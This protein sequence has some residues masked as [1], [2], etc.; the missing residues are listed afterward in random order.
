[1][2]ESQ[3]QGTQSSQSSSPSR[4]SDPTST[5]K[6]SGRKKQ[7]PR[8][9]CWNHFS[10]YVT[11]DG[12]NRS[13]CNHCDTTYTME[14]RGS[15]TSLNNHL[16]TCLQKPKGNTSDLKQ[17]ELAFSKVGSSSESETTIFSTWK[18]DGDAI[19][20]ALINM[21]V[22]DELPFRIVEGDG[23]KSFLSIACPRFHL[24]SRFTV[25]RDCLDLFN[26]MKRL[27]KNSFDKGTSRVCL[28]TDTWTSLQR[29]SYMVLTAHWV[30]D[31]WLLQKRII[32]FCPI[33]AHR[34]E[35]IGQALEKCIRDWE[36]ERV[37]TVTVDNASAN[38]VGIEYL[39]KKLN[40]RNTCVANG[41]YMHMRCVAHVINLIV[42]EG[43]KHASGSVDR[44]RAAVRYIRASPLRMKKFYDR[45]KEEMIDTKARLQLD[46][47]TRWNSTYMMLDVAAKYEHAF[48]SYVRDDNSFF[49][50]L[51]VG[52]GVPTFDDWENVRKISKILHP[53]YDITLKVS[54]S[55]HVTSN[56]FWET[57]IEVHWLLEEWMN[58][59]DLDIVSMASKMRDKY[60]KYWGD[61]TNMNF[62]VYLAIIL[63]PRRKLGFVNFGVN[64]LFPNVANEVMKMIERDLHCLFDEYSSIAGRVKVHEV[65]SSVPTKFSM[66]MELHQ[67][68]TSLAVQQYL[69]K[70]QRVSSES[71][72][73][74]DKYL[75]EDEEENDSTSFDLL[76]WWK[77]N[78]PRY[79]IL[80]QMAR[81]VFSIPISTVASESAFS[82][83]GRVL[84]GF[85][86]SLTPT[87]VEALI[88]TQDW[89]RKS[90][91]S[92]TINLDEYV[93]ELQDMED[94][95][96]RIPENQEV[97]SKMPTVHEEEEEE[98]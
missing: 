5:G 60:N 62:L 16:K 83:G 15:T 53:F 82:T 71:K 89:L 46:V 67:S 29:V 7:Q 11:E 78:S 90:K 19:R 92:M 18:F 3:G 69:L 41:K 85:R 42:Q 95:L 54:G 13:R 17:S 51:T 74:L 84:D 9:P 65:Q 36:I 58:C 22:V 30:D 1:M 80:A 44:V 39:R 52:D 48:D 68:K 47:P 76:L 91:D 10:K 23:F 43:V 63:D 45:A 98:A 25:R 64:L 97:F 86:S 55:L 28:T 20:K 27:L 14:N 37:F 56:L 21:I 96:S 70:K 72:S 57:L 49:L 73:E 24:P 6:K 32:N 88:C 59:N 66:S 26:S 94:D 61:A 34:G 35:S 40:H 87:M 2:S 79:P 93:A 33:S 81:D 31:D 8:A 4:V 38:G 77:V 50:D 12:E 75:T